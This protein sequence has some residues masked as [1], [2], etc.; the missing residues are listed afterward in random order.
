MSFAGRVVSV[1]ALPIT[2][3]DKHNPNQFEIVR[4]RKGND[5][6]DLTCTRGG[7]EFGLTLGL[8]F[9]GRTPEPKNRNYKPQKIVDQE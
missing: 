8:S 6:K 9:G 7:R 2:F 1:S 3:L 4:F 5:D